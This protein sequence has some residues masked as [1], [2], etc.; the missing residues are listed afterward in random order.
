MCPK[1][2]QCQVTANVLHW[3][4]TGQ[5]DEP[6]LGSGCRTEVCTV[7]LATDRFFQTDP[8]TFQK[9]LNVFL[10]IIKCL[11]ELDRFGELPLGGSTHQ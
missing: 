2:V 7:E 6:V 11:P 1:H 10:E 4:W 8:F 5:R 3:I 9:L